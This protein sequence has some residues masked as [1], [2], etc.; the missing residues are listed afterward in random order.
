MSKNDK[1]AE[2]IHTKIIDYIL[3]S[4]MNIE[5][6]PDDIERQMYETILDVISFE[7]GRSDDPNGC[8]RQSGKFCKKLFSCCK[9]KQQKNTE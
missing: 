6:I 9:K 8:V 7:L 2:Q 5:L 4:P 3:A 1:L